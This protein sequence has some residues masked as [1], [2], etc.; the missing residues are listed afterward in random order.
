LSYQKPADGPV[1]FDIQVGPLAPLLL[2]DFAMALRQRKVVDALDVLRCAA[3]RG[4]IREE[5]WQTNEGVVTRYN[6]AFICHGL[7]QRDNGRV[8]GYDNSHGAHHRHERG[9]V[10]PYVFTNY[11]EVL[12]QFLNEV[13]V[14]RMEKL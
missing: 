7:Y 14:L 5:V 6:L 11:E 2:Y 3:G 10:T 4:L 1:S 13:D 8:L 12:T 9:V